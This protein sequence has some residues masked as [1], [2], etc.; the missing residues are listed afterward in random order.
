[1]SHPVTK[2]DLAQLISAV[3]RLSIALER[4]S[5][6]SSSSQTVEPRPVI[7]V[8]GWELV[9]EAFELPLSVK[10][11]P[12]RVFED[13]PE[14]IPEDLLALTSSKLTSV[15]GPPRDRVLRAWKAGVWAWAANAT[16]SE[17]KQAE[18]L[19]LSDVHWVV[20]RHSRIT[21]PVRV[22]KLSELRSLLASQACECEPA[23]YQGFPSITEVQ[24]FCSSF[25]TGLPP[26]YQCSGQK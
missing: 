23:I 8:A 3:N 4:S 7:S 25:G 18:P 20:V 12:H 14:P 11:D 24:V 21:G 17:Y 2:E 19:S 15:C 26:L 10:V 5:L 16:H 13:G 22:R 9:E 6:A 1:M